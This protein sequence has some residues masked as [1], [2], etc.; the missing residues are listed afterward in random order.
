MRT[1]KEVR[2][3][4]RRQAWYRDF[5]RIILT[6]K[7]LSLLEKIRILRGKYG[8]DTLMDTFTWEDTVQGYEFWRSAMVAMFDWYYDC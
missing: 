2:R 3:Y 1:A 5:R 4:M 7:S 6:E 8:D